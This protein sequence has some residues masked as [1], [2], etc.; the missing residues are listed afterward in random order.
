M[1]AIAPDEPGA[2]NNIAWARR[3]I[4]TPNW[5]NGPRAVALAERTVALSPSDVTLD[6]L[7]A[8]YAETGRFA[9][10]AQAARKALDFASQQANRPLAESIRARIRLYEAEMPY[11]ESPMALG[12]RRVNRSVLSR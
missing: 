3:R 2:L 6:T 1:P 11:R 5:P 10:A 4:Q 9:A 8:A 12:R 7:A